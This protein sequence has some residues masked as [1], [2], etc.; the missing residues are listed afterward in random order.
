MGQNA[1]FKKRNCQKTKQVDKLEIIIH[2]ICREQDIPLTWKAHYWKK[3]A[4]PFF[5]LLYTVL[6]G[7][8]FILTR[9]Y[10]ICCALISSSN[11]MWLHFFNSFI[12]MWLKRALFYYLNWMIRFRALTLLKTLKTYTQ[13]I[14][15]FNVLHFN[16]LNNHLNLKTLSRNF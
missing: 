12:R 5:N 11:K 6:G 16:F 13:N 2:C 9:L 3:G 1:I 8:D 14:R 15:F 7:T 10:R 4:T